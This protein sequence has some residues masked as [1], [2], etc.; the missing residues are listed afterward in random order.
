MSPAGTGD[1]MKEINVRAAEFILVMQ[2]GYSIKGMD[3]KEGEEVAFIYNDRR[4]ETTAKIE[5]THLIGKIIKFIPTSR[6]K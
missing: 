3:I 6:E 1:K 5:E 2:G 4:I